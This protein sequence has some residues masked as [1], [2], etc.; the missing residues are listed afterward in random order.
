M[1]LYEYTCVS[2]RTQTLRAGQRGAGFENV[3]LRKKS[4]AMRLY[5]TSSFVIG[6]KHCV[7]G[8]GGTRLENIL[9]RKKTRATRLYGCTCVGNRTQTL[10]P[11]QRGCKV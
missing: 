6:R 2:D 3:L 7:R 1:R 10:R 5:E 4:G 9:L 8:R 11:G